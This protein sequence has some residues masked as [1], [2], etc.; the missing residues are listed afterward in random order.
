MNYLAHHFFY[1]EED[2]W[3]NTG[4]IL[5]DL[6]RA[7]PGRRKL[8]WQGKEPD[9]EDH[10]IWMGCLKHYE[11]DDWFHE[12]EYFVSLSAFIQTD[13]EKARE[14]GLFYRQ[15]KWFLAHLLGE[16]LLDRLIL[17]K[18]ASAVDHFYQDLHQVET[19]RLVKF[20]LDSGKQEPGTFHRLFE[21]F[22]EAE[23]LRH[24]ASNRGI[25]GSLNRVVQR[26]GQ[27]AMDEAELDF[28]TGNLDSWIDR[29]WKIKKPVRMNRL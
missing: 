20:L 24:Y 16:M 10:Q 14:Q 18:E 8:L 3:H 2:P 15:R 1:A 23:F 25:A 28:L 29:A 9:P 22:R 5:P 4:L 26:T 7:A 11:A 6:S 27:E 13:L 12:S 17:E 21:G 19:D